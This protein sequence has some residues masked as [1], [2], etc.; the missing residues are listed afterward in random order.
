MTI[1]ILKK[2]LLCEWR[3]GALSSA[4]PDLL[5]AT[6]VSTVQVF[7]HW[8][9]S[10]SIW[11]KM[12]TSPQQTSHTFQEFYVFTNGSSFPQ[13]FCVSSKEVPP[14]FH[15]RPL[16]PSTISP[17]TWPLN[18]SSSSDNKKMSYFMTTVTFT[19]RSEQ[20]LPPR[21]TWPTSF[22][23]RVSLMSYWRMSPCNQLEKYTKRSSIDMSMS[24]IKPEYKSWIT[25]EI[26]QL[27]NAVT[28]E[29]L[30]IL[31]KENN[32]HMAMTYVPN[33]LQY[34]PYFGVSCL[35]KV[36]GSSSTS[37]EMKRK[38]SLHFTTTRLSI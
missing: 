15:V 10:W 32:L 34:G 12:K 37:F 33:P 24:V 1:T 26:P 31:R 25:G 23:C 16:C 27:Q 4:E 11:H 2:F 29:F 14:T 17:V 13:A 6:A 28:F 8:E 38:V 7:A 19:L 30:T 36:L 35:Q 9:L 21:K 18:S 20:M 22:G 3:V 5:L